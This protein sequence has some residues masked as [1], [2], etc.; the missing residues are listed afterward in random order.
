M[1]YLAWKLY[2]GNGKVCTYLIK[3][4]CVN[5]YPIGKNKCFI[6]ALVIIRFQSVIYS[7]HYWQQWLRIADPVTSDWCLLIC[8][9]FLHWTSLRVCLH[10]KRRPK[11]KAPQFITH[12]LVSLL[13]LKLS[14][15]IPT[16]KQLSTVI[17]HTASH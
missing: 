2:S 8:H 14:C 9:F 10:C 12:R 4:E 11:N 3:N 6:T 17:L 1:L 15:L 7:S 5:I 13:T 16:L